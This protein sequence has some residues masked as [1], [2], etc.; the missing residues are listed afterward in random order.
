GA[1]RWWACLA[2][3]GPLLYHCQYFQHVAHA[4]ATCYRGR[5]AFH[6]QPPATATAGH[7]PPGSTAGDSEDS[8]NFWRN[9]LLAAAIR[10]SGTHTP[11]LLPPPLGTPTDTPAS[12][13]SVATVTPD[14]VTAQCALLTSLLAVL[15]DDTLAALRHE[16]LLKALA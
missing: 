13:L 10:G 2:L 3:A 4:A 1:C 15:P 7:S 11:T 16:Q 12:R 14:L 9:S 5:H 6:L 8:L